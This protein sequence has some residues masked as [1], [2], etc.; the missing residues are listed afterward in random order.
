[1]PSV[2]GDANAPE[3]CPNCFH[4]INLDG[5]NDSDC[6]CYCHQSVSEM[7]EWLQMIEERRD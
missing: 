5:L 3:R 7:K 1:M 4:Q 2:L 6:L